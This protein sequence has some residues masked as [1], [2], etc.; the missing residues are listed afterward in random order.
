M[1]YEPFTRTEKKGLVYT[2]A[3]L[4]SWLWPRKIDLRPP[5]SPPP[6]PPPLYF[7]DRS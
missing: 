3:E 5:R 1:S 7:T 6:S 2:T 4:R